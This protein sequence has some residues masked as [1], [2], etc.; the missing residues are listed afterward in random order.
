[1]QRR[2]TRPPLF[3]FSLALGG[4]LAL[5]HMLPSLGNDQPIYAFLVSSLPWAGHDSKVEDIAAAFR[6]LVEERRSDGPLLLAGHSLGG[7]VAFELAQQ[8][9]ASGRDVAFLA[10]IDTPCPTAAFGR[11]NRF[12]RKRA[13]KARSE[14]SGR[15]D[16]TYR[17]LVPGTDQPVQGAA[18]AIARSYAPRPYAGAVTVLWTAESAARTR[19]EL[20]GWG[21]HLAGPV[22]AQ[23]LSGDHMSIM[24][25]PGVDE[26]VAAFVPRLRAAEDAFVS[27][28]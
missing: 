7:L 12:R 23:K 20:L 5:R 10:M 13:P 16:G 1:V 4:T 21:P 17:L 9:V 15:P 3:W 2:G 24:R 28:S 27:S 6:P 25:K 19:D 18:D 26:L 11:F 22:D 14:W 8:M